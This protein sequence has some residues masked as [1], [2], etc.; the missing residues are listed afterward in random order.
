MHQ[1][2]PLTLADADLAEFCQ[3]WQVIELAIFGSALR[4]DFGPDSDI[5]L[6]ATFSASATWSLLDHMRMELE[7]VELFQREVDLIDR[8]TL[9][10]SD[11]PRRQAEI[12]NSAHVIFSAPEVDR[13][14]G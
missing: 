2:L 1:T 14:A 8:R 12:L 4:A 11:R 6:L 9:E 5:D 7:L 13:V 3:R 10:Q